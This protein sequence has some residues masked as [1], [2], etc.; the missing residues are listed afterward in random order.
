MGLRS[1][2]Y[3]PRVMTAEVSSELVIGFVGIG[4]VEAVVLVDLVV[5]ADDIDAPARR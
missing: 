3:S 1:V 4:R 5:E 2:A